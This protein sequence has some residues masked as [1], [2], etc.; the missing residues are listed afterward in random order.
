ML[1]DITNNERE[2]NYIKAQIKK[3]ELDIRD[4]KKANKSFICYAHRV[5]H[6]N[7]LRQE[8]ISKRKFS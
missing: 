2:I 4:A 3:C 5:D 8:L 7:D 1:S 6:L